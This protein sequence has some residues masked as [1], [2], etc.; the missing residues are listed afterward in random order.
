M[1]SLYHTPLGQTTGDHS[2]AERGEREGGREGEIEGM[3]V[4]GRIRNMRSSQAR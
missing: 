3:G 4:G 2:G 1:A